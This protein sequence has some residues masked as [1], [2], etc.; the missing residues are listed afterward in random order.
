MPIGSDPTPLTEGAVDV[1]VGFVN[2][3]P[4]TLKEQ[5]VDTVVLAFQD[6][7]IPS[8]TGTMVVQRSYLEKNRDVVK[9]FLRATVMGYELNAKD[10]AAG[11]EL[12]L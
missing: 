6:V 1:Y 4:L 9:N 10:P 8:Y 7:G 2:N 3:Q 11:A 5:G 12:L